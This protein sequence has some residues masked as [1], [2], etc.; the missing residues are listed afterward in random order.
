MAHV[1]KRTRTTA[2]GTKTTSWVASVPIGAGRTRTKAFDRKIDAGRWAA[3]EQ[4][5]VARGSHTNSALGRQPLQ[6]YAERWRQGQQWKRSTAETVEVILRCRICPTFGQRPL[7]SILHS[8]V[9]AWVGELSA[10]YAP[11]TVASS[12]VQLSSI[13]SAALR[14]RIVDR[15]P[16]DGISKPKIPKEKVVPLEDHEIESIIGELPGY[17][18]VMARVSEAT[19]LRLSECTGITVNRIDF[20]GKRLTVDRQLVTPSRGA[21]YLSS[22]KT[23]GSDRVVPLPGDIVALLAKHLAE[24]GLSVTDGEEFAFSTVS[25]KP[26]RRGNVGDAMNRAVKRSGI[27]REAT[28]HDFR[29]RY[30]SLLI[31][32]RMDVVAVQ[33]MLGHASARET[34]DTYSHLWPDAEEQV[35]LAVESALNT[36]RA[37]MGR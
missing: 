26:M 3:E 5:R 7:N 21:P 37:G 17:L 33:H 32:E 22:T 2:K 36:A 20:L 14:D 28:W 8:D 13:F 31:H 27:A 16:C 6:E 19:G 34:L 12:L 30:A 1:K 9:Q 29:H 4:T 15:N 23:E 35:R 10:K 24:R 18:K 25:G 11:R